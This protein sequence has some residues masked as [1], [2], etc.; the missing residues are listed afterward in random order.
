MY[1]D[2]NQ[3]M[4][5]FVTKIITLDIFYDWYVSHFVSDLTGRCITNAHIENHLDLLDPTFS[6][7]TLGYSI[8]KRP[9]YSVTI[10]RGSNRILLW[11]QM[12]GNESTTTKA[13][14]DCFKFFSE[15]LNDD[16]TKSVLDK[17]TF[18]FI[19][20]LNPD[21][22]H[23]YTRNNAADID[24]NRDAYNQ[25]QPESVVL[26]NAFSTFQ[27]HFCFNLH[28]QRSIYGFETTGM[29]SVLSFLAPAADKERSSTISRQRAMSIIGDIN[30]ALQPYLPG[31][32]GRYDDT[33]NINCVGDFFQT[34]QVPTMLFEAGHY[35]DDYEREETRKYIFIA[36]MTAFQSILHNTFENASSYMNI[37]EHQNCFVDLLITNAKIENVENN[38]IAIRYV[39]M[40]DNKKVVFVP[41]VDSINSER[42]I[43]GHRVINAEEREIV[44]LNDET[45]QEG[46]KL[47]GIRIER[48]LTITF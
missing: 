41:V 25:T 36:L 1:T 34:Q 46:N 44:A 40:L 17:F 24:L 4:F 32:V 33:Y 26:R 42:A 21:G 8:E 11:S 7:S 47:S 18:L 45:I 30:K 31:Q 14:F 13:V 20:I 48:Q 19:P 38:Q 39:E 9:I 35:P 37:P 3:L 10:G 27:P 43:Y 12:H 23:Y 16:F 28:D 2:V 29:P 5:T 22:A 6:I 15:T